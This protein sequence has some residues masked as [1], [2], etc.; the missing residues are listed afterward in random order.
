MAV[1]S[2]TTITL[3]EATR[4]LPSSHHGKRL[5]LVTL[6]RWANR[7]LLTPDGRRVRLEIAKVGKAVLTSREAIERFSAALTGPTCDPPAEAIRTPVAR[8]RAAEAARAKLE[9]IGI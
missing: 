3:A 9:A 1:L 5:S 8:K 6:W 4:L 7:G 2:E